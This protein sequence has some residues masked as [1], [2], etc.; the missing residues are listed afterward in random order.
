[1]SIA[2]ENLPLPRRGVQEE[3]VPR[4]GKLTKSSRR[5]RAATK[6]KKSYRCRDGVQAICLEFHFGDCFKLELL[7]LIYQIHRVSVCYI[8]GHRNLYKSKDFCDVLKNKNCRRRA[9]AAVIFSKSLP[10]RDDSLN[11]L[12]LPRR[13]GAR[14]RGAAAPRWTSL[15][16]YWKTKRKA[17]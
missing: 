11:N 14:G 9:A 2:A 7:A 5:C 1:M 15:V 6:F 4:R 17:T 12:P 16:P 3:K 8:R 13:P 10:R